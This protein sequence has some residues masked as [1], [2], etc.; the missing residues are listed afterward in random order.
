MR[1]T[2][3]PD[4]GRRN[5]RTHAAILDAALALCREEGYARLTMDAIAARAGAGKQTIYRWWPSKGAV[6]LDAFLRSAG[7][8]VAFPETHDTRADVRAQMMALARFLAHP[9][10]GPVYAGVVGDAQHDPALSRTIRERLIQPRIELARRVL[11]RGQERGQ[12]R[13]DADVD[14]AVS[15]LYGALYF[16][17]LLHTGSLGP[18]YVDAIIDHVWRGL[19]AGR[20]RSTRVGGS[21][22]VKQR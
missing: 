18:R 1:T 9:D 16:R 11:R 5:Q 15:L 10:T 17:L 12:L 13:A 22:P 4:A 6:V 21:S 3:A 2:R 14:A 20:R 7:S 8:A 19:D